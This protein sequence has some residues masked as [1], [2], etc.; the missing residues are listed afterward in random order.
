MMTQKGLDL[1]YLQI[2]IIVN[3]MSPKTVARLGDKTKVLHGRSTTF[4]TVHLTL[5]KFWS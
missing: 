2:Q 1:Q 5:L 4:L 3:V